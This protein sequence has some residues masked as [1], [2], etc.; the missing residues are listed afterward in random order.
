MSALDALFIALSLIAIVLGVIRIVHY[1]LAFKVE[2]ALKKTVRMRPPVRSPQW[3]MNSRFT[4]ILL[5]I[6]GVLNLAT[7]LA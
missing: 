1:D 2:T 6:L 7:V 3:E 4:G 5:L